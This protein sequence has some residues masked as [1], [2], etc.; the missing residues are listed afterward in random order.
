[1]GFLIPVRWQLY[2][3]SGPRWATSTAVDTYVTQKCHDIARTMFS[4]KMTHR[5]LTM[6]PRL[7][8]LFNESTLLRG[9]M[10]YRWAFWLPV[11]APWPIW[12]KNLTQF[13]LN[14]NWNLIEKSLVKY[15]P[16]TPSTITQNRN[17]SLQ[18]RH[19]GHDSV[20]N[21]QPHECL[22]NRLFRRRSEKTSKLRVTGLCAGNSPRKCPVTR[23]IFPFD[24]VIMSYVIV[25]WGCCVYL[26]LVCTIRHELYVL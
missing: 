22:L 8:Q 7:V 5:L 9:V 2:I 23:K 1:M 13:L 21:H 17:V 11:D 20:S 12:L 15:M 3:E 18:W 26:L 19:N 10:M 6:Y 25:Q 14:H 24:D 16:W 4:D